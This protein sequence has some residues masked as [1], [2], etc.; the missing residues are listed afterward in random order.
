MFDK[1]L[2]IANI[3]QLAKE[4]GMKLGDLEKNAGVS[5]GYLSR[6]NKEDSTATPSIDFVASV[7]KALGVTVDAIINNDYATPTPTEKFL[8]GFVDRLLSQTI[9]DELDWKKETVKQL[10]EIGC[11][12]DGIANHPLFSMDFGGYEPH[13]VYNSRFNSTYTIAGD[14]FRLSLPGVESTSIYLMCA[15]EPNEECL[16]F[17]VDDYELYMVKKWNVQPLCHALPVGSPFYE[18]L[19]SLYAAVTESSKHPKLDADVM[20]AINAFMRGPVF[21]KTDEFDGDLPF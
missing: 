14:C 11:D 21:A 1:R 4:R 10:W 8:L 6:L 2:C 19:S 9:A 7:A 16:P 17:E 13:P 5:A 15:G 3:Y 20:S 18:A 12:E